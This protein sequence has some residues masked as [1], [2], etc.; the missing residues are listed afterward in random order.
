MYFELLG[1]YSIFS[2]DVAEFLGLDKNLDWTFLVLS[3]KAKER[4]KN[5]LLIE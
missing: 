5:K 2:K 4:L 3:N 1:L